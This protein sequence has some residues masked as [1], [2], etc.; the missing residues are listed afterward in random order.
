MGDR[1]MDLR[2]LQDMDA[3]DIKK[4]KWKSIERK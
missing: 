3:E 1:R 2:E 4:W